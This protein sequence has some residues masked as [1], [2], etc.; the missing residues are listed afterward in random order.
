MAGAGEI[1]RTGRAR[2]KQ[3]DSTDNYDA[4]TRPYP[5]ADFPS[6][7]AS[8]QIEE[9]GVRYGDKIKTGEEIASNRS[10]ARITRKFSNKAAY[11]IRLHLF[12]CTKS[13][14]AIL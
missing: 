3:Y 13:P 14:A 10:L 2:I 7:R 9:A 5:P 1:R 4:S 8:R 11:L 12:V 6:I